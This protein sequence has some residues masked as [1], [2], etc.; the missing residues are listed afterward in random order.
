MGR[1]T[2]SRPKHRYIKP[3]YSGY[4]QEP[5]GNGLMCQKIKLFNWKYPHRPGV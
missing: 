2:N 5:K 4:W 1:N 3:A